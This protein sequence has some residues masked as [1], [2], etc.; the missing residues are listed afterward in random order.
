MGT[1]LIV[2]DEVGR[3]QEKRREERKRK[4]SSTKLLNPHDTGN[5]YILMTDLVMTTLPIK[6]ASEHLVFFCN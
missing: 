1:Y 5:E 2:L 6:G 3:E 4:G